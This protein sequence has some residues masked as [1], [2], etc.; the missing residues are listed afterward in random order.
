MIE[1]QTSSQDQRPPKPHGVPIQRLVISPV[2]PA[3]K[4]PPPPFQSLLPAF[5]DHG[6]DPPT[7]LL[8]G[9][10]SN[11]AHDIADRGSFSV[12]RWEI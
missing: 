2:T 11:K 4:V 7:V 1:K 9:S 5:H 6:D 3:S 8:F 12:L 10:S